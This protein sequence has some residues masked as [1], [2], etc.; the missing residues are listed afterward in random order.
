MMTLCL[1]V[2]RPGTQGRATISLEN[3]L[4]GATSLK[5]EIPPEK[6]F[7]FCMAF[8]LLPPAQESNESDQILTGEH[9]EPGRI[10][11]M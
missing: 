5:S 1:S 7:I 11:I 8:S 6:R 4:C 9:S 3:D 2:D 10:Y